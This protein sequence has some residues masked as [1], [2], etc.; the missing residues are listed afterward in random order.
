MLERE[1]QDPPKS[2]D[3]ATDALT[4]VR[5]RTLNDL[6]LSLVEW[7]ISP[8][9][10]MAEAKAMVSPWPAKANYWEPSDLQ[11]DEHMRTVLKIVERANYHGGTG[12]GLRGGDPTRPLVELGYQVVLCL[13]M[14]RNARATADRSAKIHQRWFLTVVDWKSKSKQADTTAPPTLC[15]PNTYLEQWSGRSVRVKEPVY[16][17]GIWSKASDAVVTMVN[18]GRGIVYDESLMSVLALPP[19]VRCR[20]LHRSVQQKKLGRQADLLWADIGPLMRNLT[21]S[22]ATVPFDEPLAELK[23]NVESGP[24]MLL[25]ELTSLTEEIV[26]SSDLSREAGKARGIAKKVSK[27]LRSIVHQIAQGEKG[28]GAKGEGAKLGAIALSGF[29]PKVILADKQ[30]NWW[31]EDTQGHKLPGGVSIHLCATDTRRLAPD[32]CR[33]IV[34]WLTIVDLQQYNPVN[35]AEG[36]LLTPKHQPFDMRPTYVVPGELACPLS[37]EEVE[38]RLEAEERRKAQ[39]VEEEISG[40]MNARLARARTGTGRRSSRPDETTSSRSMFQSPRETFKSE[41]SLAAAAG[42]LAEETLGSRA[43]VGDESPAVDRV[44]LGI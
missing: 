7:L 38:A 36:G 18:E 16:A 6:V 41:E 40:L 1:P 14:H 25:Q 35:A 44:A 39:Q 34:V 17:G 2:A 12:F 33:E 28:E 11:M 3:V 13:H 26:G 21:G 20:T 10:D 4:P 42:V 19:G 5:R 37:A 24:G 43:G 27:E 29:F 23:L 31:A 32:A 30:N 9:Q 22:K 8:A 15:M